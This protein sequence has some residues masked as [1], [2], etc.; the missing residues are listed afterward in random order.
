MTLDLG[1]IQYWSCATVSNVESTYCPSPFDPDRIVLCG[2]CGQ[3]FPRFDN[4]QVQ[5][6]KHIQSVHKFRECD[7]NKRF[8]QA[9]Y[10][11]QHIHQSHAG[12]PGK[13]FNTLKITCMAFDAPLD[14]G[15]PPQS[16]PEHK[17]LT[18]SSALNPFI[19]NNIRQVLVDIAR[20]FR[21]LV[22]S[23]TDMLPSPLGQYISLVQLAETAHSYTS[24][25]LLWT[26]GHDSSMSSPSYR[27]DA[28]LELASCLQNIEARVE[29]YRAACWD[30]GHDV[31]AIDKIL[32]LPR[33]KGL[34]SETLL[35]PAGL[36]HSHGDITA[37]WKAVAQRRD[38]AWLPTQDRINIW[39]LHNL[40]VSPE[41]SALHRSFLR[42]G[43]TL[44][45]EEWSRLVMKFWPLDDAATGPEERS[46]STNGAVDSDG[47]RHSAR[48]SLE[49]FVTG[50]ESKDTSSD[51]ESAFSE[52]AVGV[53][54]KDFPVPGSS[55]QLDVI[56]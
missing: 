4:H 40:E 26:D 32:R 1:R 12:I 10:F 54:L 36:T 30:M 56:A 43:D 21:K 18:N 49:E 25:L 35:S 3:E 34:E 52:M 8:F 55:Q 15:D 9:S 42:G 24:L 33:S 6:M 31:D 50:E 37:G 22:D 29:K 39:L 17:E 47:E 48:V 41:H 27:Y 44:N 7:L 53:A 11:Q 45:Q 5:R 20:K 2:Y 46:C 14:R 13:W 23:S 51:W 16:L 38:T 19:G 28:Q